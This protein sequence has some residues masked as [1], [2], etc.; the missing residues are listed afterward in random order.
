MTS[1]KCN[2]DAGQCADE[3]AA[4]ESIGFPLR[5]DEPSQRYAEKQPAHRFTGGIGSS[6]M[7]PVLVGVSTIQIMTSTSKNNPSG[8]KS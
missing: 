8:N 7:F 3:I 6:W 4:K 1:T 2:R 5:Q